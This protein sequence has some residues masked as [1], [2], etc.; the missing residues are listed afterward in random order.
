MRETDRVRMENTLGSLWAAGRLSRGPVYAFG[1]SHETEEMIDCLLTRGVRVRAILDN[2]GAKLGRSYRDVPIRR[3]DAAL[4][5]AD[6]T[7][8]IAARAYDAMAAQLQKLG[9]RGEVVRV[10]E[11]DTFSEYSLSAETFA[12]K[13]ERARRGVRTLE[14]IRQ[15]KPAAHLVVCPHDALG[16]VYWAMAFLPA[17]CAAHGISEVQV[18]LCGDGCMRVARLFGVDDAMVLE[19]N[20][21]DELVQALV[22]TDEGNSLIAHHDRPYTDA[23]IHYLNGHF[24]P[25]IDYY[26]CAV[27]GLP[28]AT[29]AA[30]PRYGQAFEPP[31]GLAQGAGVLLAPHARSVSH[32]ADAFWEEQAAGFRKEGLTVFT[33]VVGSEAPIRGTE[34]IRIPLEQIVSAAET[35]GRFVG[36]RS[37]LCD[38]LTTARCPKTVVFPDCVYS[39]TE[40][41]VDRFF[42]LPGWQKMV[43]RDSR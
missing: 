14:T 42:D 36:I 17:Y 11:Y 4:E 9:Y 24:L 13:A 19:R 40:V 32:V 28:L 23:V 5:G 8:L 31:P 35:M 26:R 7:V 18:V 20:D 16:D 27:Y 2:N 33:N 30:A 41:K 38:L 22:F 21:M 6:S 1:H 29:A 37:G 3:P 43:W 25:F 15:R 12:C 10:V 34:P 39:T